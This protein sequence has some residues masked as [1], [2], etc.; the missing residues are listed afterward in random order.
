MNRL[1][2]RETPI[3]VLV[4]D[5]QKNAEKFYNGAAA[6][7][8]SG[9][10]LWRRAIV[11]GCQLAWCGVY[12]VFG[13]QVRVWLRRAGHQAAVEELVIDALVRVWRGVSAD[14]FEAKLPHLDA[15]MAY[16]KRATFSARAD[17]LRRRHA[18]KH[19]HEALELVT[20]PVREL[21]PLERR[22]DSDVTPYLEAIDTAQDRIIFDCMFLGGM[23]SRDVLA[24]F[25][26]FDDIRTVYLR[27]D[28]LKKKLRRY[29]KKQKAA[30]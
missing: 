10:E 25:A 18:Q 23:S 16:V 11:D 26:E 5:A 8:S 24:R 15:V 20:L 29:V 12:D 1:D 4:M 14:S 9:Y 7:L 21:R 6:D 30:E 22:F 13:T 19:Q 3:D 27:R 28:S 17:Y 2:V